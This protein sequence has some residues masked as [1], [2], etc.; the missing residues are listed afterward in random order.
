MAASARILAL[1][2]SLTAGFGLAANAA[3]PVRLEKALQAEG[4]DVTLINGG[5]SGDTTA[6]GLARL[7][8]ALAA[9]PQ[10]VILELGAN[11]ALRGLNPKVTHANLDAILKR[12]TT[13]GIGVLLAGMLAPPNM[14]RTFQDEF[15][16]V[17]DQLATRYDVVFYPFFLDGVAG[18][19]RLVQ[20]DGLHPT[21]A[22]VDVLVSH[23]LP[24]VRTLLDRHAKGGGR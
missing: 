22:G 15:K 19:A 8:W 9:K 12:L 13:D 6:G 11:D 7:D 17:Y 23:I 20:S 24:A 1:G 21:A 16:A 14:G 2:D 18:D 5:V 10:M 4:R 3:F